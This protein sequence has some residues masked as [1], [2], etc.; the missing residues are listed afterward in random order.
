MV[1]TAFLDIDEPNFRYKQVYIEA[2]KSEAISVFQENFGCSPVGLA[3]PRCSF[4]YLIEEYDTLR[5]A[6]DDIIIYF[7]ESVED[8]KKRSDVLF[9]DKKQV[10]P[11]KSKRLLIPIHFHE[12][13]EFCKFDEQ[14]HSIQKLKDIIRS[15][16]L[17]TEKPDSSLKEIR[18]IAQS[19]LDVNPNPSLD[20]NS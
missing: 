10:K 11:S 15:I 12:C 19:G 9:I 4:E 8:Y 14:V 17:E 16:L 1:W 18:R 3:C 6:L 7:E 5:D 2:P 20:K 13:T